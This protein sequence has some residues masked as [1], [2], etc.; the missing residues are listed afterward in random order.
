MFHNPSTVIDTFKNNY[1]MLHRW[2]FFVTS[3]HCV[4]VYNFIFAIHINL[5]DLLQTV[6]TKHIIFL[7]ILYIAIPPFPCPGSSTRVRLMYLSM[8][9]LQIRAELAATVLAAR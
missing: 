6:K 5:K 7:Q 9:P 2:F 1:V 4:Y 3:Y 8:L